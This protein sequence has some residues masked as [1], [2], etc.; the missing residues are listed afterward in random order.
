MK[1]NVEISSAEMSL[2]PGGL[3]EFEREFREQLDSPALTESGNLGSDDWLPDYEL[4]I[5]IID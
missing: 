1:I 5:V 4:D 3:E 2:F